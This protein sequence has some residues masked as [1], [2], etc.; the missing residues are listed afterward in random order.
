MAK[1]VATHFVELLQLAGEDRIDDRKTVHNERDSRLFRGFVYRII[2]LVPIQR[3]HGGG[4]EVDAHHPAVLRQSR[5]LL[6]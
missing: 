6:S 3:I 1:T 2:F 4:G 5:N